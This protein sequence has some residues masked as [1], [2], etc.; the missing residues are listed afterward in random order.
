MGSKS[1]NPHASAGLGHSDTVIR[2]KP[3]PGESTLHDL[4]A[5]LTQWSKVSNANADTETADEESLL[6]YRSSNESETF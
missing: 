1:P 4:P 6:S 5:T 2:R 3:I